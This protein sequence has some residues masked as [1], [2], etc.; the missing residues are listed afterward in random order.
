MNIKKRKRSNPKLV[1]KI[2]RDYLSCYIECVQK[3]WTFKQYM[4]AR[5]DIGKRW[6]AVAETL[7]A[8]DKEVLFATSL[9][10]FDAVNN[11]ALLEW[12]LGHEDK[13]KG[14]Y[15]NSRLCVQQ[16]EELPTYGAHFWSHSPDDIFGV[17]KPL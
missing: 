2:T 14:T 4:K 6:L 17:W 12:R 9:A 11:P 5:A 8:I 7:T 15:P 16:T 13:S 10:Y 1:K 3:R